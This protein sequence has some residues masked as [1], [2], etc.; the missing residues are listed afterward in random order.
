MIIGLILPLFSS[1]AAQEP[2][3]NPLSTPLNNVINNIDELANLKDNTELTEE[4]KIVKELELRKESLLGILDLSLLEIKNLSNKIASTTTE[5]KTQETTKTYL[6][7]FLYESG[8]YIET[9]KNKFNDELNLEGIKNLA[10]EFKDWRENFYNQ[11]I[12]KSLIFSLIMQEKA[13]LKIAEAR[14]EKIL[15]DFKKLENANLLTKDESLTLL[16]PSNKNLSNARSLNNKAETLLIKSLDFDQEISSTTII[17][18]INNISATNT[19]N[20]I[21]EDSIKLLIQKSLDEIKNAYKSFLDISIKIR[22]KLGL[23]N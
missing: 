20:N 15:L 19:I 11:I 16:S 23:Q 18:N 10:Q 12:K 14:V 5:N 6:L 1:F 22:K 2:A 7:N 13:A 21:D 8:N 4:Q 3:A 17:F 9:I